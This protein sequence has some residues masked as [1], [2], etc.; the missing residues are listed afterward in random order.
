M[1]VLQVARG[2]GKWTGL[3]TDT[4]PTKATHPGEV[5]NGTTFFETDTG[6]LYITADGTTWVVNVIGKVTGIPF[7]VKEVQVIDAVLGAYLAGDVVGVDDCCTTTAL[8]W[9]ADVARVVG[10]YVLITNVVL[11]NETPNQ[12]VQYDMIL[13]NADPSGEHRDNFP[14]DNPLK[15]DMDKYLGTIEIPTSVARGATVATHAEAS[16]STPGNLPMLVKCAT[17][18]TKIYWILVTRTAYTQVA[19]DEIEITLSGEQ[20]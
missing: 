3:S 4:K 16:P 7:S 2:A 1:A 14:N 19:T 11:A 9:E 8:V 18:A 12:A 17:G 20:Y 6:H 13:F 15:A 5:G 10:G